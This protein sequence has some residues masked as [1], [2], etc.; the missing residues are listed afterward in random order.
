ME[1]AIGMFDSRDEAQH[2]LRELLTRKVPQ[3]SIVF[4]TRSETDASSLA[5]E[6]GAWAGGFA[7]GAAGTTARVVPATRLE[8]PGFGQALALGIG[9]R[10]LLGLARAGVSSAAVKVAASDRSVPQ[11]IAD[12]EDAALFRKVLTQRR[13]LIFVRTDW[14][15]VANVASEI[16]YRT[17][18][19][20][21]EKTNQRMQAE[22][23][24]ASDVSV[25]DISGRITLGESNMMLRNIVQGLIEKGN[26]KI[27]LNLAGV[28]YIDST[29]IGELVRSL[30]TI[31]RASGQLKL[32]NLSNRVQ[33][34]LNITKV[35]SVFG[36]H[37]DEPSAIK[38]FEQAAGA[39]A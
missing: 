31:R 9:A 32:V 26:T 14:R 2:A 28:D 15:E 39:E 3:E 20:T 35:Q 6:F 4:L 33:E 11:P 7:G 22:T 27:L 1:T 18:I 16:L 23:R 12:N 36:I 29:G 34:T 38:S 13:S 21:H 17:G 25:V 8:I 37:L 10:E 24:Q 30:I 19:G 5:K